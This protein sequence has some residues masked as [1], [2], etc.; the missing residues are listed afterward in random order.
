[1]RDFG[2]MI[3]FRARREPRCGMIHP[4]NPGRL[5]EQGTVAE[6]GRLRDQVDGA[7]ALAG[8]VVEAPAGI[9]P[10]EMDRAR[11]LLARRAPGEN[12][13]AKLVHVSGGMVLLRAA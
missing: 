6:P 3:R 4:G 9:G 5:V 1:A 7:R 12:G 13:G 10:V 8:G 2:G 11:A